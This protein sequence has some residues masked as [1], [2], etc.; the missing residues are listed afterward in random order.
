MKEFS[1]QIDN[2]HNAKFYSFKWST[3]P[4]LRYKIVSY[5]QIVIAICVKILNQQI[6]KS[7]LFLKTQY[8][9]TKNF[10]MLGI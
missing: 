5:S 7:D 4:Y 9:N 2:S 3:L 10:H 1:K 6:Q 8:H